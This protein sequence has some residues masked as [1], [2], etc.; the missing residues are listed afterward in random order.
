MEG[1]VTL[2]AM[3]QVLSIR[4][5]LNMAQLNS[6]AFILGR[7]NIPLFPPLDN[8]HRFYQPSLFTVVIYIVIKRRGRFQHCELGPK[9]YYTV[10]FHAKFLLQ[11]YS[12]R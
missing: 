4:A 12:C 8:R 1:V 9:C 2:L 7:K 6:V 10:I 11:P 3:I 5:A